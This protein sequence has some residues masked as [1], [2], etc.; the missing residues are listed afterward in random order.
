MFKNCSLPD[1]VGRC[2]PKWWLLAGRKGKNN[3]LDEGL[4]GKTTAI[5]EVVSSY[6]GA[7]MHWSQKYR[8]NKSRAG[9]KPVAD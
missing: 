5:T 7:T 1:I 4:L 2:R 9:N 6:P 8:G 3:R